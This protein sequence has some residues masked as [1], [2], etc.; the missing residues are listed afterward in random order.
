MIDANEPMP[1]EEFY[2]IGDAKGNLLKVSLQS[3]EKFV[4]DLTGK[5]LDPALCREA[6]KREMEF[7][8]AKGLWVKRSVKE[9]WERTR[10]PQSQFGGLKPT[11][12]MTS[13]RTSD[14]DL[15]L[16]KS[17]DLIKKLHLHRRPRLRHCAP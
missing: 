13:P 2:K 11:R 9:C 6:R 14:L 3:D 10:A 12:A 7:V 15:L 16:G 4:D 5:P 8:R 17:E 1:V